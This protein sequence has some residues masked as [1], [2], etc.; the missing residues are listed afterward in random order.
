MHVIAYTWS[1]VLTAAQLKGIYNRKYSAWS[2][3]DIFCACCII[4]RE[5]ILL[6]YAF[7]MMDLPQVSD[8]LLLLLM[9][10]FTGLLSLHPGAA[11]GC[12]CSLRISP[13]QTQSTPWSRHPNRLLTKQL[14]MPVVAGFEMLLGD[15]AELRAVFHWTHSRDVCVS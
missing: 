12:L 2:V 1:S 3:V 5:G 7:R 9:C 15:P 11:R 8:F 14:S 4:S 13:L 10:M 6:Q